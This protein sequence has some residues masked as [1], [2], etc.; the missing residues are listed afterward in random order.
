MKGERVREGVKD[1]RFQR[2]SVLSSIR[3]DGNMVPFVFKGTLKGDLFEEYL[4]TRLVPTLRKGDVVIMDN[5]SVHK[6]KIV[7]SNI[8]DCGAEVLYLPPYSPDLN[9][10]ELMWSKMKAFLRKV[11]SQTIPKLF[12]DLHRALKT[13]TIEDITSWFGHDGYRQKFP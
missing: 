11:R 4:K 9:P 6:M 12:I 5:S 7:R 13:M 3:I 2:L 1:V 10:I 8:E